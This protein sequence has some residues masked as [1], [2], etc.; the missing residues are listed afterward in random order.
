[1]DPQGR[2]LSDAEWEDL[3]GL[4]RQAEKR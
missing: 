1:L 4:Y 2:Y 3:V